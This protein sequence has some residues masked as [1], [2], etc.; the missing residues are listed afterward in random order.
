MF[1][2]CLYMCVYIYIYIY[3]YIC[4]Y[5]YIYTPVFKNIAT[6]KICMK[7]IDISFVLFS[8]SVP[9]LKRV[10]IYIYIYIGVCVCV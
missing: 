7:Y 8:K 1:G 2:V 5:I 10:Y 4:I 6:L 9:F 3:I